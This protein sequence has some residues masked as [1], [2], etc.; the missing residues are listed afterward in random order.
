MTAK[1]LLTILAAFATIA[2]LPACQREDVNEPLKLS[3]KVFISTIASRG[4]PMW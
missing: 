1:T 2:I 4:Q 3:G